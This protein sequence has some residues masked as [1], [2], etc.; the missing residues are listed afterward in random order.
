MTETIH[1][2]RTEAIEREIIV[3]IEAGDVDDARAEFDVDAIADEVLG[4]YEQ[5][6]ACMV[7]PERFWEIVEAHS[8]T[9]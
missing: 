8:L 1:T 7:D 5:G 3:P 9:D 2:T 6:Y 4:D